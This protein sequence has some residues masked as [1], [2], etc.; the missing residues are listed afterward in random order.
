MAGM[1]GGK[2]AL[3]E[4][5]RVCVKE[6]QAWLKKSAIAYVLSHVFIIRY[7]FLFQNIS[8][9]GLFKCKETNNVWMEKKMSD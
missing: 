7:I 9:K 6:V 8:A 2:G 5:V 1:R 4:G 3:G